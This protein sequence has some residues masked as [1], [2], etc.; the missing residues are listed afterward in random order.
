MHRHE[1][2]YQPQ[3]RRMDFDQVWK[4]ANNDVPYVLGIAYD[5]SLFSRVHI[6]MHRFRIDDCRRKSIGDEV[7]L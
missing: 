1:K 7:V 4:S 6:F 2:H 5:L 3:Y